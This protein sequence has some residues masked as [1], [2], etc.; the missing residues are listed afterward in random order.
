M[1]PHRLF[2]PPGMSPAVGFSHVVEPAAGRVVYLGGQTAQRPDG[3]VGGG[4]LI[5]QVDL[6]LANVVSALSAV[7][8][9]PDHVVSLIVYT[10]DMAAYRTSLA[11]IGAVW[12]QHF[13]RHFPAMALLGVASLFDPAAL[14]E[15][16]GVAVITSDVGA[17]EPGT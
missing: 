16:V 7:G 11:P 2:N 12:R 3:S 14:V 4:T 9:R 6:A 8:G 1:T 17:D 13:G 15:L 5:E 10:T